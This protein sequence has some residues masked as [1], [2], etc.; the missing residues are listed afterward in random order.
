MAP[1]NGVLPLPVTWKQRCVSV[2]LC[3]YVHENACMYI[4][5]CVRVIMITA[6]LGGL[7]SAGVDF[8]CVFH[9][10]MECEVWWYDRVCVCV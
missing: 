9:C 6:L 1:P 5:V 2:C 8:F 3:M 4:H 7:A 10:A